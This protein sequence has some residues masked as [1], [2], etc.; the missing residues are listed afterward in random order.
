MPP[1]HSAILFSTSHR[2]LPG[3]DTGIA[4]AIVR[5]VGAGSLPEVVRIHETAEILAFGR[6]DTI[7]PGYPDAVAAA[8]AAG[9]TPIERLAGGR[10]AVFHPG[11]LAFSWA[12]PESDPRS[13]VSERFQ[14]IADIMVEAF[15]TLG[16]D[17]R[18]GELEGEYCPGA[19]SVH[20]HGMKIMGVGQRLVRGAAHVG[21]VVSVLDGSRIRDVLIP[22]YRELGLEWRPSTAGA[23]D[24]LVPGVTLDRVRKA[25]VE[26]FSRRL[27]LRPGPIP[28]QIV[29]EGRDLAGSH[30]PG[31]DAG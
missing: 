1:V 26:S 3:H 20:A 21:G 11:T 19:Y 10:A 7:A 8:R 13:G 31:H 30:V 18:I 6:H 5:A 29:D 9:F 25:I 27:S 15:R 14:E 28:E 2:E 12:M 4:H 22:V 23:L 17:A 24:E 16:V